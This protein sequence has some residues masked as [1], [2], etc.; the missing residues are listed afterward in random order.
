MVIRCK[1]GH[2]TGVVTVVITLRSEPGKP[3]IN[4]LPWLLSVAN[5]I[6]FHRISVVQCVKFGTGEATVAECGTDRITLKCSVGLYGCSQTALA[7]AV[8]EV[9]RGSLVVVVGCECVCLQILA[10]LHKNTSGIAITKFMI[11][12]WGF[13]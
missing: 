1:L 7:P 8:C 10:L 2:V 9:Y 3:G 12:F 5:N 4:S 6:R 13:S 11:P